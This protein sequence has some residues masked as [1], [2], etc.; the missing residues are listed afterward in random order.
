MGCGCG[1]KN[2]PTQ[3]VY[4]SPEGKRTTYAT[5]VQAEAAKIRNNGGTV[6]TR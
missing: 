5:E 2:T 6:T 3:F 4:I 1:S